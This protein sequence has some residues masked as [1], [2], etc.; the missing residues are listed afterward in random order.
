VDDDEE[1]D[2]K[3]VITEEDPNRGGSADYQ[4]SMPRVAFTMDSP[5]ADKFN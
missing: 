1:D 3:G 4:P 5:Q 2:D